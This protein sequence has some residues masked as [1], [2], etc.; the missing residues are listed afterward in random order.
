[1]VTDVLEVVRA[2]EV[3]GVKVSSEMSTGSPTL[4]LLVLPFSSKV[5]VTTRPVGSKN[6]PAV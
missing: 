4:V 2:V 6:S 5:G 3:L 1:M